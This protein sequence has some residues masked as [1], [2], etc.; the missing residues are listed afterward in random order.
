M[1]PA[2]FDVLVAIALVAF[3]LGALELGFRFGRRSVLHRDA[4]AGGQVGAIQGALLGLLGLLLGFSFAAAGARFLERQ[5]LITTEANAIGTAYLRA[6]LLTEPHRTALRDTL[7]D[8]T[9]HRVQAAKRVRDGLGAADHAAVAAFH[10]RMW[11]AARDGVAQQPDYAEVVLPAV[12]DVI[13]LHTTRL[14]AGAK[15]LPLV[16]MSLLIAASVLSIG[17]IGFGV[18]LGGSRRLPLTAPL[19]IVIGVALWVTIDLDHPR[20]GLLQLNDA[21][22]E[23]LVFDPPADPAPRGTPP[24]PAR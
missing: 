18:G 1:S 17:V 7:R 24:P 21:P 9:H 5:D 22:L 11:I 14:A 6:E 13:D 2:F 3:M 19:A 15:H 16:V 4:P 12:N 23:N 20:A 10:T 8:Y